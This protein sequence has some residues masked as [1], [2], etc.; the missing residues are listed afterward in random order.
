[1]A[2]T[3]SGVKT[4]VRPSDDDRLFNQHTYDQRPSLYTSG[5]VKQQL[6]MDTFVDPAMLGQLEKHAAG[7]RTNELKKHSVED[8]IDKEPANN[9][10]LQNS[11]LPG[12][13][14]SPAA[15]DMVPKSNSLDAL[16]TQQIETHRGARY[17]QR[18]TKERSVPH[19][20]KLLRRRSGRHDLH[21][22]FN[23]E[24]TYDQDR[25]I[26]SQMLAGSSW[27]DIS[28]A[29]AAKYNCPVP[30]AQGFCMRIWRME[31][32]SD[33]S[34]NVA[35]GDAH[36]QGNSDTVGA[37]NLRGIPRPRQPQQTS[38]RSLKSPCEE[39]EYL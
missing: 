22:S 34:S 10:D 9:K 7:R 6:L 16:K 23:K 35:A 2:P 33:K 30:T 17:D 15:R 28:A 39:T 12:L 26:E 8:I 37:V 18:S 1:M 14:H 5:S 36:R 27:K 29:Y 25:W 20:K 21:G 19:T 32:R 24:N 13:Q 38:L 3:R 11:Q 31:R 4:L